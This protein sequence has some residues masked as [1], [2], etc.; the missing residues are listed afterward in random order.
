MKIKEHEIFWC[1]LDYLEVLWTSKKIEEITTSLSK[2]IDWYAKSDEFPWY[3]VR[4][5]EKV[6]NYEYKIILRK[7][8]FDCFAYHKWMQQWSIDTKDF[9]S[10][11]WTA[12]RVFDSSDEI[13]NFILDNIEYRW[14]RRF[15]I[16]VDI[17]EDIKDVHKNFKKNKWKWSLFFDDK[18]DIQTFYIWE[19]QKKLNKR[20]LI[21]CYNKIDDIKRTTRQVLYPEYL[22]QEH[23]TRIEIEY[24]SELTK[25]VDILDLMSIK[26]L[27]NLFYSYISKHTGIFSQI[28]FDEHKLTS[29]RKRVSIEDLKYDELLKSRYVNI[30]MWYWKTILEIWGCPVDILLR[31][32]S[33]SEDT[34]KDIVLSIVDGEFRQ[35]R[36]E[37]WL[38]VRNSRYIFRDEDDWIEYLSNQVL[39]ALYPN[40][41]EQEAKKIIKKLFI[42]WENM[43]ESIDLF[44][45]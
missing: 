28:K 29:I 36:Y 1:W 6:M 5:V 4:R 22:A 25:G 20:Q 11:Y 44:N 26:F 30:F 16:A 42:F 39:D 19:K 17:S 18:W 38:W 3:L 23:I 14:L 31:R 33:I 15:D 24:R 37:F 43:I 2:D 27:Y 10:A 7:N 8:G 35:D 32:W 9:I 34:K 13:I 45:N 12:F 21:R 40:L 41:S